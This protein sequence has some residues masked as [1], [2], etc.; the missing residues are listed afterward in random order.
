[1]GLG[2]A[3]KSRAHVDDFMNQLQR[4]AS[5]RGGKAIRLRACIP[6]DVYHAMLR[7]DPDYW[8]DPKNLSKWDVRKFEG[9][10]ISLSVDPGL[11]EH[12]EGPDL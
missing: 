11:V 12:N 8:R 4:A 6:T 10:E 9:G 2:I 7:V 5:L 1:M 3:F